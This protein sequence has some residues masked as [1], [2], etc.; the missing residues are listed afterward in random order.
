MLCGMNETPSLGTTHLG[1]ESAVLIGEKALLEMRQRHIAPTP[2]NYALIY[3]YL[4]GYNT[5]LQHA[6]DILFKSTLDPD[7]LQM[8]LE[9]LHDTYITG[10][11]MTQEA[12]SLA[13]ERLQKTVSEIHD[14]LTIANS[15][16]TNFSA[17]LGDANKE[18]NL[19]MERTASTG[20]LRMQDIQS[21]VSKLIEETHAMVEENHYLSERVNSSS[22]ELSELRKDLAHVREE[23]Y[24]DPLTGA[25]NRKS[26]D[27]R[28]L[29]AAAECT[30]NSQPLT[31]LLMDVDHFK[32]FNDTFGHQA[33]DQVLRL[34][35][36]TFVKS[37]KGQDTAARYGGEEFAIILPNTNLANGLRV[38][39][40]LRQVVATKEVVNRQ[41]NKKLGQITI[42]VGATEYRPGESLEDCIERADKALYQ[43]KHN[44]RN[45]V[46]QN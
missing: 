10:S 42:S 32:R 30:E 19:Q 43:A 24:T 25:A 23:A 8:R 11:A 36:Q 13:S 5:E 46:E 33:G 29:Q 21:V 20:S 7:Q 1:A 6:L 22:Q 4:S 38:A 40:S 3:N 27:S 16:T 26:F 15:Q 35:A 34:V 17:Q 18:L 28:L 39:E 41:T 44:G 12:F 2:K 14:F 9:M 37:V 45:R 31:L